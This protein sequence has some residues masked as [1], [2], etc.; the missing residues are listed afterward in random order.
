MIDPREAFRRVM[1]A[2]DAGRGIELSREEAAWLSLAAGA[3]L[4]TMMTEDRA[5]AAWEGSDGV[6]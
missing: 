6:V 4:G 2:A 3:Y 1:E 5:P